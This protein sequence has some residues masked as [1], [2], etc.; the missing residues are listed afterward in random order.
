MQGDATNR[1]VTP[2][3]A[4][5]FTFEPP[6]SPSDYALPSQEARRQGLEVDFAV[7][8]ELRTAL[9]TAGVDKHMASLLYT[10]AIGAATARRTDVQIEGERITT[11]QA[12]R[13]MWK[14]PAYEANVAL[15]A[16]EARR[17]FA[18]MPASV[19]NG[20]SYADW[21]EA[22]GIGSNKV[23]IQQLYERAKGRTQ[24]AIA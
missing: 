6:A 10:S 20:A 19:T 24:G 15:A 2:D 8:A 5:A 21:I 7:E 11:E 13:A 9:H 14:G 12:L 4:E 18:A 23:L 17:I 22:S 16:A 1:T 3:A